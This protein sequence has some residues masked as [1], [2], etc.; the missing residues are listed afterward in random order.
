LDAA[1]FDALQKRDS[2]AI[3]FLSIIYPL[4][5]G[6]VVFFSVVEVYARM[7]TQRR[8]RARLNNQIINSW[9]QNGH[10]YQ[11]NFV[12]GAALNP[13]YRMADDVRIATEAP[14][15]LVGDVVLWTIR[16]RSLCMLMAW[17]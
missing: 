5:V 3:L 7:T 6:A 9:L 10:Y 4:L 1:I 11:L 12:K 16:V 2:A 14:V 13:E 17:P 15:D 8:W